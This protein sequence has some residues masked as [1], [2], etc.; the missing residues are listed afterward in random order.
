MRQLNEVELAI[1]NFSMI[2]IDITYGLSN[3][4][5]YCKQIKKYI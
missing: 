4:F 3:I 1:A 2:Y 5:G